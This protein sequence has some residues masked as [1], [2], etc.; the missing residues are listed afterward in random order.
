MILSN[1]EIHKALDDHRLI[2]SPEPTPRTKEIGT[3]SRCPYDTHSVDLRLGDEIT[4]P[5]PAAV[6][7]DFS[8]A[9]SIAQTIA[10]NS[11]KE[12]LTENRPYHL[13]KGQFV[14]AQTF[15]EIGLPIDNGPP[16]LAARIEGKSSRARCGL[17]VHFTAP[18]IHPDWHGKITLE[19][20]N[21][22]ETPFLLHSQMTIAQL[23][24]EQVMGEIL[25]NPSQFQGQ[26][27][28]EG[29]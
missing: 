15:E 17:L 22:G 3:T 1:S 6:A 8:G 11:K 28:P 29:T 5:K 19:I 18:T 23:I 27:T 13:Q 26:A 9:G 2:I 20:M 10:R 16:Y 4:V 24:V 25:T 21:L 12:T 7:Y 14:L